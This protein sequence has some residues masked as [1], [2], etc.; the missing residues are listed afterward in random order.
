MVGEV[1]I[2]PQEQ[3]AL[4]V[5]AVVNKALVE[6]RLEQTRLSLDVLVSRHGHGFRLWV[7]QKIGVQAA[8]RSAFNLLATYKLTLHF[9]N[10]ERAGFAL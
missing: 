1:F 7:L 2:F 5:D 9:F 4:A 10:E 3:R 6:H 8:L